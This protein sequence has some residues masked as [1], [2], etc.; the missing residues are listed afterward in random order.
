LLVCSV[1]TKEEEFFR[2][3]LPEKSVSYCMNFWKTHRIQLVISRPRKSVYGNYIF[4]NGVH[5]ISVNGDLNHEAF[6]V[7][8]LHEVAHLMV[9]VKYPKRTLP[10]GAEWQREFQMIMKPMLVPEIFSGEVLSALDAHL[11]K[12]NATSCSDPI[13]HKILMKQ[14]HLEERDGFFA[15]ETLPPG[16][17]FKYEGKTFEVIRFLRTRVE[18]RMLETGHVLRFSPLVQVEMLEGEAAPAV[19]AP[20]HLLAQVETH[21][22]FRFRGKLYR[23]MEKKRTRF[24]CQDIKTEKLFLINASL[25]VEVG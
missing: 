13:L 4:R 6:L 22:T 16:S 24:L 5:H 15:V 23:V 25:P 20:I 19:K 2:K 10:H 12:P 14:S 9:R 11:K 17:Y 7:T 1:A 21:G 8:Y 18:C 3:Y